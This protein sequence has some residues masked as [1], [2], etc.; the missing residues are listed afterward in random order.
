MT[1][2]YIIN[3]LKKYT[4]LIKEL[5]KRDFKVKY[6]RSFL[7]I[8]WSILYPLLMMGVMALVFSNFFKATMPGVSYLCYLLTGLTIFNYF[9]DATTQSMPSIVSNMGLINKVYIPKY[10]FPLSK[11]L[12]SGINFLL[13][14]IPLYLIILFTG[15]DLN[16]YHFLLPICF[17]L[18]TIF[19][20]GF[21]FFLSCISVFVRDIFYLWGIIT[22]IWTYLTPIMYDI[23]ILPKKLI[24]IMDF[25]PLYQYIK[26]AR[27]II[28]YGKVPMLSTWLWCLGW[29]IFMF[30]FGAWIFR[31]N[32]NKFIYYI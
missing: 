3:N 6:Q 30:V 1:I 21:G 24:D 28:L 11:C 32:Q 2:K 13:T 22:L 19:C 17:F 31:K 25:N 14:L 16:F 7:G 27:D 29:A 15:T 26:F 4:F 20:I 5:I 9:S 8:L 12:F 18:L 23:S 10:I